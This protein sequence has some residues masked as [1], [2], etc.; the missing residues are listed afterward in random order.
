[1]GGNLEQ[2]CQMSQVHGRN[3]FRC[4]R[5]FQKGV[6]S[7]LMKSGFEEVLEFWEYTVHIGCEL[8]L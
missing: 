4:G 2:M 7:L 8:D 5:L 3:L 1:M 6:N